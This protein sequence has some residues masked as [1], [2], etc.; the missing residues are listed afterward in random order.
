MT[1]FLSVVQER[2][3]ARCIKRNIGH[4]CHDEPREPE[5]DTKKSKKQHSNSAA[6]EDDAA[7]EH[8]QSNVEGGMSSA[9]EPSQSQSQDS[10]TI[11]TAAL[12]QSGS[13]QLVQP[14]PVSGLQAN[15]L[16]T[17]GNQCKLPCKAE[18]KWQ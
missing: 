10:L 12:P 17:S 13:L 8:L 2:P 16:N 9:V 5:S 18:P 11:G 6:E 15:A 14:S 3:C 1:N 4:L 7:A